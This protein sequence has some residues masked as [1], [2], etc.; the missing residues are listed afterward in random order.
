MTIL[1]GLMISGTTQALAQ[2]GE[3]GGFHVDFEK[4][5]LDNGLEVVLH[6]DHSDP[7][8]AVAILYHV[9]SSREKPGKTGFA[10]F[11]E[12][13][14][15]QNSENVGKGEF[16]RKIDD[17]GGTFNGGTWNDGTV[18]YE[19]VPRDALEKIFWMESDR[20][21]FLINTVTQL[22]LERE[23][24]IVINEK[25]QRVDNQPY[26]HTGYVID[27]SLFGDKHPYSWQVI[28]SMDDIR[29]ATLDDVREFY[30]KY[31]AV[32]NATMVVA[33]DFDAVEVKNLINKYFGEF[34]PRVKPEAFRPE[35][36]KLTQTLKFVHEDNF[37]RLPELTM[38]F[39]TVENYHPD[40]Y[41]LEV[42]A[43]L[44]ADGKK[45]PLYKEIVDKRKLAPRISVYNYPLELAGKFNITVRAFETVNLNEVYD[46]IMEG[47]RQFEQNGFTESDLQ[48]IKNLRETSFY[49]SISSLL[50]KSFQL[51]Q[52][53]VFGG[54]P[55]RMM[56]DVRLLNAVT[57]DDVMRVYEKYIRNANFI[58]T[59]FVPK[60]KTEL[61]LAGSQ[62]AEI[63]EESIEET[64]SQAAGMEE[65]DEDY[66]RT[67]TTFDRTVEPPLGPKPLLNAPDVYTH[68]LSNGVSVYG[69]E[70]HEL[71]LIQFSIRLKGGQTFDDPA[72]PGVARLVAE[73]LMEGTAKRTPE[74]LE[75]AIG[76][77]GAS[78]NVN[79]SSEF[80]TLTANCL[81]RNYDAVRELMEE[82]LLEPRWDEA[83]FE[84]L[85]QSTLSTIAQRNA[86]PNAIAGNVF[87]KK[88]YG[89]NSIMGQAITGTVESVESITIS[90]LKDYYNRYFTPSVASIHIA[91]DMKKETALKSFTGLEKAWSGRQVDMVSIKVPAAPLKPQLY[92]VDVPDAKQS[93]I[94]I[95]SIAMKRNDPDFFPATFVNYKLGDGSGSKLFSVLRLEKGYT[96]GAYSFIMPR[97]VEGPFVAS[98]SVQS[99]FTL[100]SLRLFNEILSSYGKE[101]SSADLETTRNAMIRGNAGKFETI[102][103]LMGMLQEISTFGLPVDYV[104]KEERIAEKIT[105][106][107]AQKIYSR[108]IRP[109]NMVYVVV[110]DARTQLERL[111]EAG[112][113]DPVLVDINGK[114]VKL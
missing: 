98:S 95:G 48:R 61:A 80:I 108:Y 96:Y 39:P 82:I 38:V 97:S 44:L 6:Q 49:N 13:M 47:F 89:E 50:G 41:A 9:G 43:D 59:S 17:L 62:K 67:P 4:Y 91:G 112:L 37:A 31:Y 79:A 45:A 40:S 70:S 78:M 54:D 51:S 92:F 102:G 66:P 99:V 27:K 14:L 58:A 69:I 107:E 7:I 64:G 110:G 2:K 28:G 12:H 83:E 57:K 109:E 88:I 73:M 24:D 86:N 101:Y 35:P 10:H 52:A 22:A 85:K 63:V 72:K 3:K 105:L 16:F 68:K 42:L 23:K 29:A 11:F 1:T 106:E 103:S 94:M 36:A 104:K 25:R 55:S 111:K 113:G 76:Q 114:P 60:G 20:M 90:D 33:G 77:L 46:A 65:G 5:K 34:K 32:N 26:G 75:E 18:Y 71:P 87:Y 30:D 56:D 53:N 19:V 74:E 81:V 84:R 100:E 8:V 21:G 15:F 93:V